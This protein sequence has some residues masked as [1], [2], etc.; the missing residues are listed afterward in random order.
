[1]L[2]VRRDISKNCPSFFP[3]R[4]PTTLPLHTTSSPPSAS[5]PPR[6]RSYVDKSVVQHDSVIVSSPPV[7]RKHLLDLIASHAHLVDTGISLSDALTP[8]LGASNSPLSRDKQRSDCQKRAPGID[9]ESAH[10][11][12]IK[13][14][15]RR[16]HVRFEIAGDDL[17]TLQPKKMERKEGIEDVL[18]EVEQVWTK[19]H[20]R[21]EEHG[22]LNRK[23]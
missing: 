6:E 11:T 10:H 21:V 19:L 23:G 4:L 1:M 8:L 17:K 12:T 13:N 5:L 22:V 3:D 15:P 18:E 14:V 20:G 2:S 7:D 9:A 16:K